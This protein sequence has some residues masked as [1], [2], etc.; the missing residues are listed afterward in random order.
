[1]KIQSE[2]RGF[3]EK[4]AAAYTS[5][6]SQYLRLSRIQKYHKDAPPFLKIGSRVI[7][8]RD[9]LD[10]WLESHRSQLAE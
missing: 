1:M 6:S 10:R 7:Y 4:E 5:L 3:S 9:D 8:L 2:I